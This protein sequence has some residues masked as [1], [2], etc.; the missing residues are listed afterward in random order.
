MRVSD[1]VSTCACPRLRSR[2][3]EGSRRF[4]LNGF[5]PRA[6]LITNA[7]ARFLKE[8]NFLKA[9]VLARLRNL[10]SLV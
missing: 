1:C 8:T 3:L 4:G 9:S 6:A 2:T 10:P 5:K 7:N